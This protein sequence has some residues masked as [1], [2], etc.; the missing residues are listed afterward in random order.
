MF[1]R[2]ETSAYKLALVNGTQRC[3]A[4]WHF[5]R[6]REESDREIRAMIEKSSKEIKCLK[7]AIEFCFE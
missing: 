7:L 6:R 1:D 2:I 4:R 3:E 5:D